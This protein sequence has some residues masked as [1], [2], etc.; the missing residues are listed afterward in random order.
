MPDTKTPTKTCN[1]CKAVLPIT[2]FYKRNGKHPISVCKSCNTV[3]AFQNTLAK[4]SDVELDLLKIKYDKLLW[5]V[6]NEMI[7]RR[8]G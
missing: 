7:K 4:V 2:D 1:M 6:D 8:T 3:R 5:S